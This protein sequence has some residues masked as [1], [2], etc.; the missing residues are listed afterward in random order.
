MAEPASPFDDPV[1]RGYPVVLATLRIAVAVQCWGAAAGWLHG[2]DDYGL[3]GYLVSAGRF[4]DVWVATALDRVSWALA[5]CGLLTLVRPCWP[6]LL[7]VTA[8]FSLIA[9]VGPAAEQDPLRPCL[10]S[11]RYLAPFSLMLLDLWPPRVK[12]SLGRCLVG[13]FLLRLGSVLT[14]GA[15]A[16]LALDQSRRGGPLEDLLTATCQQAAQLSLTP[17]QARAALGIIGGLEL[18][19]TLGLL[20]SRSRTMA[21]LMT[22]WGALAAM[23]HVLAYGPQQF[24]QVL[25]EAS[26]AGAPCALGLYWWLAVK[27][28]PPILRP[29]R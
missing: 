19:L 1:P 15:H 22:G 13:L 28:Q 29:A 3:T 23:S 27:E 11:V 12:F 17:D 16:L 18:G 5:A 24:Y 7:P 9:A 6:V 21:F 2:H 25:L 26:H 8:W 4:T 20:L 10:Q 14:F